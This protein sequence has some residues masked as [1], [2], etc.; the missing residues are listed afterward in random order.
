[1]NKIKQIINESI[2]SMYESNSNYEEN[3]EYNGGEREVIELPSNTAKSF[4]YDDRYDF[5]HIFTT[6]NSTPEAYLF[7][8]GT[9]F[10]LVIRYNNKEYNSPIRMQDYLDLKNHYNRGY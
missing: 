7:Y 9:N 6:S 3:K 4:L 10:A 8:N 2:T 1:M 5:N